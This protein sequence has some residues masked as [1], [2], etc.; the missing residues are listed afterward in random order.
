ML[1]LCKTTLHDRAHP[2]EPEQYLCPTK[3][4]VGQPMVRHSV[5]DALGRFLH[6]KAE[7]DS[8]SV[9]DQQ[10][11][12]RFQE[13]VRQHGA[14]PEFTTAT[15]ASILG[16]SRMHLNRKLRLLTGCST[17]GYIQGMRLEEARDLLSQPWPV[18]F[19]ARSCGFK[20]SSHFARAFRERFGD[21]P[22]GFRARQSLARQPTRRMPWEK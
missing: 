11:L 22:S 10:F 7:L 18:A 20:S 5:F 9:G 6:P 1:H 15:A 21:S 17:H 13:V 4:V 12:E 8:H 14:D 3:I 16:M 2:G 19:V